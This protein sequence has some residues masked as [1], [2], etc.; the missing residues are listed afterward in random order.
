VCVGVCLCVCYQRE[1]EIEGVLFSTQSEY[2]RRSV[3]KKSQNYVVIRTNTQTHTHTHTHTHTREC[4]CLTELGIQEAIRKNFAKKTLFGTS[5]VGGTVARG[6]FE[7]GKVTKRYRM[8]SLAIECV[9]L[10]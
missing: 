7:T 5:L 10:L 2:R 3:K 8:C 6:N 1:R 9:L 4:K